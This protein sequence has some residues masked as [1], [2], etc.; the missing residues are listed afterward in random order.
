MKNQYDITRVNAILSKCRNRGLLKSGDFITWSEACTCDADR[1]IAV[2]EEGNLVDAICSNCQTRATDLQ[3]K[4]EAIVSDPNAKP[5]VSDMEEPQVHDANPQKAYALKYGV[6]IMK[7]PVGDG[8]ERYGLIALD[9]GGTVLCGGW[10]T[11]EEAKAFCAAEGVRVEEDHD[12][13]LAIWN[14]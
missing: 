13:V 8:E 10:E 9:S 11:F 1:W 3:K 12:K 5:D 2:I 6:A 14:R 4:V 7:A